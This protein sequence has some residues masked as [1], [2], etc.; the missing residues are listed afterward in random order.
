MK[1]HAPFWLLPVSAILFTGCVSQYKVAVDFSPALKD[2]YTEFPTIEVDIAAVTD[3][4]AE[5]VKQAGVEKY[6]APNSGIRERLQSQTCYFY[7]EE[8]RSFVLP[9]RAPIWRDWKLKK[10]AGVL[11][12]ASLPQ[13]AS[14]TPQTDSR[15]IVVKMARSFI[16]ARTINILVEPKKIMRVRKSSSQLNKDESPVAAEQWVESRKRRE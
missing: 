12:I 10:P 15:Y 9:S 13:D 4:E 11:V 7:R 8:Q 3:G 2:Y 6:F 14:A 1:K 16:I 5:E